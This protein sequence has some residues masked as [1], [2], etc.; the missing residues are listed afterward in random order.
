MFSGY[1]W[2]RSFLPLP[3]KK[4]EIVRL[5]I[6]SLQCFL[7][8]LGDQAFAP[9]HSRLFL[10]SGMANANA[11]FN[12]SILFDYT[13][14]SQRGRWNALETLS[15]GV[16]SGSAFIGGYMADHYDACRKSPDLGKRGVECCV[17]LCLCA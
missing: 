4:V 12:K 7:T 10:R 9:S 5:I 16:W 1:D 14:S 13:P 11:P 15:S 8:N 6:L 2:S 17:M 3:A